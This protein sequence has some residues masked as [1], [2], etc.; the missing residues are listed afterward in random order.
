VAKIV[1]DFNKKKLAERKAAA[2][3][4]KANQTKTSHNKTAAKTPAPG[5]VKQAAAP[6]PTEQSSR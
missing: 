4:A 1:R 2:A 5:T 3:V 6:L